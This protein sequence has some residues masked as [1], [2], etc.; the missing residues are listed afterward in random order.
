MLPGALTVSLLLYIVFGS[1]LPDMAALAVIYAIAVVAI[2]N[3]CAGRQTL[4]A[5]LGFDRWSSL[6]YSSYM[7]H[8]P[9]ATIVLTFASRYLAPVL[10]GGKLSLVPVAMIVLA[11]ASVL[12]L[13]MFE[14]PMR[15]Y[16]NDAYDRWFGAQVGTPAIPGRNVI[17]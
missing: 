10:P 6:T 3:D 15:R 2:Q 14:N 17:R 16:L 9:V 5:K 7:L 8:I 4:F 13:R 12:S 1:Y 11:A